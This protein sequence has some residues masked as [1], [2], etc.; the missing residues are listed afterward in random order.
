ML[1][2]FLKRTLLN[3]VSKSCIMSKGIRF[4][5]WS[6]NLIIFQMEILVFK[7]M[8]LNAS[9]HVVLFLKKSQVWNY[10]FPPCQCVKINPDVKILLSYWATFKFGFT[11][12]TETTRKIYFKLGSSLYRIRRCQRDDFVFLSHIWRPKW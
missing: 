6:V 10:L 12:R 8:P 4:L 1:F 2:E 9:I 5:T 3:D 11:G 7:M